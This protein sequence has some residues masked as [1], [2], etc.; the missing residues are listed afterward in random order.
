LLQLKQVGSF[1]IYAAA[2]LL[3]LYAGAASLS[4]P[5]TDSVDTLIESGHWKHAQQAVEARL[6][7]NPNDAQAHAWLSKIKSG[8]GDLEGSIAEAERAVELDPN[9]VAFHGQLAEAN[10]LMADRSSVLKG[11]IYARHMKKEIAAALATDPNHVD[12]LLVQMMYEWKAP[13]VAG[14]DRNQAWQI[15]AHIGQVSPVWGDLA[16]ARLAQD[17]G[18]DKEVEAALRQAV[19]LDPSF[20]RAHIALARFY[21]CTAQHRRYDRAEQIAREAIA[22]DPSNAGG[23]EILARVYASQRRGTQLNDTLAR[24]ESAA[25]DDLVPYYAAATVL[26]ESGQD[27]PHAEQ[28]LQRYLSRPVEGREP[29]HAEACWLLAELYEHEGR[30]SDAVRE[31]QA[32]VHL[33]PGFEQA[34]RD[35]N[36]LRH[37]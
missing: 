18:N 37:S 11:L 22:L 7:T 28:Y 30:K 13:T 27:F 16:R 17:E 8:F 2:A 14:G 3:C 35:L 15:A 25:P 6:K 34:R 29:S 5:N 23:W 1:R 19:E 24:A 33:D 32:A 31:L 10:A 21:C 12:T 36:R 20:Y 26:F 4:A 9:S